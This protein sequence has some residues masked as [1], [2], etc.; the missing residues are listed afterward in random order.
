PFV[1]ILAVGQA[2]IVPQELVEEQGEA[3]GTQ[4]VGTGP[5]RF[6]RWERG[7]EIVLAANPDYFDGPPKLGRLVFRIFSGEQ[8]DR[9]FTEF[10][11]GGL[12]D[13]WIPTRDYRQ[14]IASQSYQY[15]RRPIFN[16]RHYGFNTRIKPLDDRRVRQAIVEAL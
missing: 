4:P 8:R 3:F 15:F 9:A 13:C 14:I 2:K 1:S 12:E 5:F 16:L 10:Q 7:K 6:V 11:A